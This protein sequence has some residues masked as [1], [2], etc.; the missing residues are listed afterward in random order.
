[1]RSAQRLF[2][3][4]DS[5]LLPAGVRPPRFVGFNAGGR[6]VMTLVV[7]GVRGESAPSN[8]AMARLI[9]SLSCFKSATIL[10]ISKMCSFL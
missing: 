5:R 1:L 3:A 7:L 10:S 8:A 2:I 6:G 4:N 9:L